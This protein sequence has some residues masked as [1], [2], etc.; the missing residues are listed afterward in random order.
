[1]RADLAA[2][3]N[4]AN[5]HIGRELFHADRRSQ[6]R[7][8]ATDDQHIKFHRFPFFGH[9]ATPFAFKNSLM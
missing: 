2:L 7:R 4:Q 6:A 1:M 9:H 3:F 8:P 5:R